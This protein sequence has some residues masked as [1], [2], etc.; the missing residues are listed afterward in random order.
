VDTDKNLKDGYIF[1]GGN[2]ITP[3]S[4][5]MCVPSTSTD[6]NVSDGDNTTVVDSTTTTADSTTTN[7]VGV[8]DKVDE[9][10]IECATTAVVDVSFKRPSTTTTSSAIDD[11]SHHYV[12]LVN[13]AMTCYLNS[14]IQTLYMTPEFRN[15]LY[16]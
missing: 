10:S 14:L 3:I 6:T 16:E 1:V 9:A 4:M 11:N 2:R 8:E 7:V 13:Q 12:G 15:A 5:N